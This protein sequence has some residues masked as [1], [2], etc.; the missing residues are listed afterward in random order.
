MSSALTLK[1]LR[2]SAGLAALAFVGLLIFALA[3]IGSN[4]LWFVFGRGGGAGGGIPFL[5]DSFH[6]NYCLAA[7]SV[8]IALGLKQSLGD[9]WGEAHLFWL[10]RPVSRR[11]VYLTKVAVGLL[12]YLL[13]AAVPLGI[14]SWWA[15]SPGTHA[16]PF[17]WSM[18]IPT[19]IAWL[20]LSVIYLG[21]MLAGIRPAAWIGT[22]LL[23]LVAAIGCA[24]VACMLPA[25]WGLVSTVV[26]AG[27]LISLI[28]FVAETRDFA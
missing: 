24:L 11:R 10:H 1:E 19:W 20:A 15:A 8:G 5:F 27:V 14:Y 23:P 13:L 22:R 9:L 12:L 2:E 18:A 28:V 4:P 6:W 17:E 7:A 16:S 3:A 21:A 26:V 25:W